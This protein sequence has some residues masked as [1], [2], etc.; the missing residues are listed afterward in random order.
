MEEKEIEILVSE[1][2]EIQIER[3]NLSSGPDSIEEWDSVN[4]LRIYSALCEELGED[5]EFSKFIKLK[6]IEELLRVINE[7]L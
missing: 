7:W 5:F 3:L 4:S 6:T 2:L 1:V